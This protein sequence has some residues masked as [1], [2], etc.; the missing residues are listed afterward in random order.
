M[1]K[2]QMIERRNKRR[3]GR[4]FLMNKANATSGY[5]WIENIDLSGWRL[6][7]FADELARGIQHTG[8]YTSDDYNESFRG[9]VYQLLTHKGRQLYFVGYDDPNNDYCV[10]G[11]FMFADDDS[12]AAY[13]ADAIARKMAEQE[14]EYNEVWRLGQ[15]YA[16]TFETVSELRKR[17]GVLIHGFRTGANDDAGR[18]CARGVGIPDVR[19]RGA[20]HRPRRC[21]TPPST[22]PG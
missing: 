19:N 18:V 21:L 22:G 15:E 2:E 7:G 13:E 8:W 5:R 4:T 12:E 1:T 3:N 11:G 17:R 16:Q 20:P 6:R 10:Y 14:R 9:I